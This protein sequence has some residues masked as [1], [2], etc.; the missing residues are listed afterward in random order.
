[1]ICLPVEG[2]RAVVLGIGIKLSPLGVGL[3]YYSTLSSKID[4]SFGLFLEVA[5]V[6]FFSAFACMATIYRDIFASVF[7]LTFIYGGSE[8]IYHL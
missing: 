5:C 6:T 1:M 8:R 2:Q 3:V 7:I 4:E